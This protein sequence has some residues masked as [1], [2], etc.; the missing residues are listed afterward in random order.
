MIHLSDLS[1]FQEI[2]RQESLTVVAREFGVKSTSV[3]KRPAKIGGLVDS[4][5]GNR[6]T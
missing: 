4:R 1:F 3:S 6:G 5:F 2:A